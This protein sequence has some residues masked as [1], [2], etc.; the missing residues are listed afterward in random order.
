VI[1]REFSP[2]G[3]CLT[4]RI[5]A[6]TEVNLIPVLIRPYAST[7]GYHRNAIGDRIAPVSAALQNVRFWH[8][9]DIMVAPTNVRFWG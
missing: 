1:V 3:S 4:P 9:A 8:K 5:S 7:H 2:A 6:T